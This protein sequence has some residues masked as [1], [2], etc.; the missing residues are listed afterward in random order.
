MTLNVFS[1][2]II[3]ALAVDYLL[4]SLADYLNLRALSLE[5]PRS[6]GGIYKPDEYRRSQQYTRSATR[7][8]LVTSTFSLALVLCFWLIGGFAF[9]DHVV[10]AW[11]LPAI[12]AGIV[13]IGILLGAYAV[14]TTPFGI[15]HTFVIEQRFGFNRTTPRL[16]ILDRLKSLGL[17]IVLG[18]PLL[19]GI[20]F[21]F[22]QAGQLAWLYAWAVVTA[23]SLV[24]Q[25]LAPAIIL[26]LF[27]KF[28]PMPD[29][30]LKTAIMDYARTNNFPVSKLFV[31]D[32]SRRSTRANA[33]F[34]GLGRNKRIALFD[35][36]IQ[37]HTTRELVGVLAHEIGHY[38]KRHVLEATMISVAHSGLL[39]FLL[40][41]FI[42]SSGLFAAF[43]V[44][45]SVYAGL[46]F[47]ALLYTPVELLLS[48]A[49]NVL[50]R[51]N[52][53]Q[54][55]EFAALTTDDPAS[56]ADALKKLAAN[57][58]SNLT[59]HPFYVFLTYSHPPLLER[60]EAIISARTRPSSNSGPQGKSGQELTR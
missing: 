17:A 21:L 23:F 56:L 20:L 49:M 42:N 16:F 28:T 13:Y 41:L 29:G 44:T 58:L 24:I 22:Q 36:L 34:T 43:G 10:R 15:Y 33:Y 40:S 31:V 14:L 38:K 19:A 57:N 11:A 1:V 50:S 2:I 37:Q 3:V 46:I 51:R 4:G 25:Y 18:V 48:I 54:A 60:V 12:P 55:D 30:E 7:F 32:S 47:F 8:G 6:L 45:P 53:N 59:P 35:T 26:P 52:E 39:F 5:I 27:N 9:V